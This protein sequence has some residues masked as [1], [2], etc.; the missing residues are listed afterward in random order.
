M[1]FVTYN[2]QY[3]KGRDG[4]VNLERIA[5]EVAG[6][7]IIALQEVERF[8]T[9][10]GDVDQATRL[11]ELLP[12]YF[13]HYGPG[14]DL[15]ASTRDA[16][17]RVR[18][19]RR[20]FGNMLL[21]KTPLQACRNHLL[22]KYAS[23][24]PLS[25]QRAALE[26]IVEVGEG[27]AVRAYSIHLTHLSAETRL[28]QVKRLLK[29][30]RRAPMEGV[31][32]CGSDVY[33]E[34][35][36]DG[37]PEGMPRCAILMG[38]FN[39]LPRSREYVAIVGPESDYGGIITN[40]EGFV[41]AWSWSGQTIESGTTSDIRGMPARLD[42]FFVSAELAGSIRGVRVDESATGSDHQPL[43]MELDC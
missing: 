14:V 12:S 10:S 36:R 32:L 17:G 37:I 6:A 1:R 22:P 19:R 4:L 9:R 39:F 5:Q 18:R 8:W 21:A 27:R 16:T 33:A 11:G 31:A 26:A 23:C 28:P 13:W 20:Q 15:D 2:I 29:I 7:D 3:G 24:G 43:W 42:Y 34:L 40:P 38:D 25:I 41:D 30:H 35:A